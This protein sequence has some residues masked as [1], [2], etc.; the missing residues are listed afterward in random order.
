MEYDRRVSEIIAEAERALARLAA[1]AAAARDYGRAGTLLAIAERVGAAAG[2]ASATTPTPA[3]SDVPPP[4]RP[5]RK[6]SAA[7]QYPQFRREGDTLVKVGWSKS[8]KRVYEHRSPRDVLVRLIGRIAE[9]GAAGR[10]FVTA[11]LFPLIGR[12][13]DELPGYQGYLC[14]A[15][16]VGSGVVRKYGRQGY[17]VES[18]VQLKAA[19]D[20]AWNRLPVG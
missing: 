14:L 12:D 3:A 9:V 17:S 7:T 4:P 15:W 19:A 10:R 1:E 16:L 18:P 20:E 6:N 5:S 11:Q 13:G 2:V 8:D